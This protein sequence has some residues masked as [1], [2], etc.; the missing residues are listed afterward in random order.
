MND[1]CILEIPDLLARLLFVEERIKKVK[2]RYHIIWDFA[3][4]HKHQM[5]D[6]SLLN[7]AAVQWPPYCSQLDTG[8]LVLIR[9]GKGGG[10]VRCQIHIHTQR[11]RMKMD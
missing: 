4:M 8:F 6:S 7:C 11:A 9:I 10:H 2:N 5:V 3:S 1:G